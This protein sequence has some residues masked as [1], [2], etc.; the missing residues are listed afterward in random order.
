VLHAPVLPQLGAAA[1]ELQRRQH[2]HAQR[3][4]QR[5]RLLVARLLHRQEGDV[6][7][8][9]RAAREGVLDAG[10]RLQRADPVVAPLQL[11]L[12]RQA[13]LADAVRGELDHHQLAARRGR[14]RLPLGQRGH[15]GHALLDA[16][17]LPHPPLQRLLARLAG[18]QLVAGAQRRGTYRDEVRRR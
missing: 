5:A 6:L 12:L 7:A 17:A 16:R 11:R 2:L 9:A 18:P 13:R 10:A 4:A 14:G 15:V 1:P 3:V 8:L